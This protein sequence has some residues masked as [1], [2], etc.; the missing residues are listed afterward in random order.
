MWGIG[1]LASPIVGHLLIQ[2]FKLLFVTHYYFNSQLGACGTTCNAGTIDVGWGQR[3][4]ISDI[5]MA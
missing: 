4:V 2:N 1:T 3:K 5:F